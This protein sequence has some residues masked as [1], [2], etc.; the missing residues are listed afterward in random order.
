[1]KSVFYLLLAAMI[2]VDLARSA[3]RA[4]QFF[5]KP[6]S[7][8]DV[9]LLDSF[10]EPAVAAAILKQRA[11]SCYAQARNGAWDPAHSAVHDP[12]PAGNDQPPRHA[13][14]GPAGFGSGSPP[15]GSWIQPLEELR[16]TIQD[17]NVDLDQK[18][19]VVYSENRLENQ[20]LDLFLQL[21]HEAPERQ[22]VLNWLPSSLD[23][24]RRCGRTEELED[25]V[26]CLVRFHPDLKTARQLTARV[27][28]WEAKQH[29]GLGVGG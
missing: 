7:V 12:R 25:A 22:E 13:P 27:R 10:S 4:G 6:D 3:F 15:V 11:E 14:A 18:L 9:C 1:M 29:A 19:L 8:A 28:A 21:L 5:R 26:R 16:A 17:L 2:A 24:S 23:C 20:L